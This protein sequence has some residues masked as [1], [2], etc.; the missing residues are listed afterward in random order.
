MDAASR[1]YG[2]YFRP[3]V[4][5][6]AATSKY[7]LWINHLPKAFNP[8]RAYGHTGYLVA[9]SDSPSGPFITVNEHATLSESAPGDAD[10]FVDENGVDAYIAYN[11]WNNNHTLSVEKLNPDWTDSMGAAYN[12]GPI[13]EHKQEAP[14][15][16]QRNGYY[17]L[18]HGHTCCFCKQGS[19]AW[20]KVAKDP[21]GP[22]TDM[23]VDLNPKKKGFM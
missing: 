10:I 16:F 15:L 22:W 17:Y 6:N 23:N 14:V 19:N 13:T 5:Y 8:L 4:I 20:V 2:I 9:T 11:G 21:L 1:P 3:K 18:L 12:S 7:I